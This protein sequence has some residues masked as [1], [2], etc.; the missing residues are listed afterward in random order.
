MELEVKYKVS[1]FPYEIIKDLGFVKN[2]ESHQIDK[3]F[4]VDQNYASKRTYLRVRYDIRKNI[5]SFDLHQI[6]SKIATDEKE[7]V[8][9]DI[10]DYEN[11]IEMLKI[12]GFPVVCEVDKK[13][14]TFLLDGIKVVFDSVKDLGDFV[15]IEILGEDTEENRLLLLKMSQQLQLDKKNEIYGKGYPDMI[16]EK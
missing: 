16:L 1:Q 9:Y 14:T 10:R 6:V 3:Y 11:L 8:I 5:F 13:R 12:L 2:G 7:I 4:I 15:E